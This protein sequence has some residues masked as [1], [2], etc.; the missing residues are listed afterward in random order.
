[1]IVI[2]ILIANAAIIIIMISRGTALFLAR[3]LYAKGIVSLHR[4]GWRD[5]RL[6]STHIELHC[7]VEQF[8]KKTSIPRY[9][10]T[11][12][13]K[14]QSSFIHM[15]AVYLSNYLTWLTDV[16]HEH[17]N[18]IY[19]QGH[20]DHTYFSCVWL[21]M[22]MVDFYIHFYWLHLIIVLRLDNLGMDV[23]ICRNFITQ[24]SIELLES[25]PFSPSD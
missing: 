12:K 4:Y 6:Q 2:S 3:V 20:I 21:S 16:G 23:C 11:Y 8:A 9:I 18:Y 7:K 24:R 5:E 15:L 22:C 25:R 19:T 10:Y 13:W 17:G 14:N 1:M